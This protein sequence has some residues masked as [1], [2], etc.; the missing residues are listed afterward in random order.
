M[1]PDPRPKAAFPSLARFLAAA[2][3]Q[4]GAPYIWG[5]KGDFYGTQR[6]FDCSGLV[7]WA[8]REAGGPDWR[9]THNSD[10]LWEVLPEIGAAQFQPGDLLFWGERANP[11]H[12]GI[13]LGGGGAL[14]SAAGGDSD[15]RTVED[16]RKAG[17]CVRPESSI[18][19]RK[20]FLGARRLHWSE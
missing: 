9:G 8:Y 14:L 19:Y 4:V 20:G 12:V 13:Y 2:V 10:V 17:A 11:E 6:T 7:T 15:T 1:R 18:H 16:A 5:A 3:S